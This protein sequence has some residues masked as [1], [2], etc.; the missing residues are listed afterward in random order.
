MSWVCPRFNVD[1]AKP[2]KV[3][4]DFAQKMRRFYDNDDRRMDAAL[5]TLNP[6]RAVVP[7]FLHLH[8]Y[9]IGSVRTN[10]RKRGKHGHRVQEP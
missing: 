1:V 9:A 8:A 6:R 10:G 2:L 3:V 4:D 5:P 7:R